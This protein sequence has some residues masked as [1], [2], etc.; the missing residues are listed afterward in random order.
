[1]THSTTIRRAVALTAAFLLATGSGAA[2]QEAD[3]SPFANF[4]LAG[5]GGT[6]YEAGL[7]SDFQNDFSASVSPV[8][9]YSM[10]EDLLFEAE[11][12]F[13]LSGELTTTTL[14]YA[15][16]D[17]LGFERVQVT[18]GKFLLPFGLFGERYHPTWVNELPSAP[19]LFGHAHGGVAEEALMPILSDAGAMVRYNHPLGGGASNLDLSL[20]VTQGPRLVTASDEEGG[21]GHA[22]DIVPGEAAGHPVQLSPAQSAQSPFEIPQVGFGVAFADNNQ[23]KMLGGRLGWVNGGSFEIHLS[24]FHAMYDPDDFLD[25]S[26]AALSFDTRRGAWE[27]RG[28]GVFLRQEFQT[29]GGTF[30]TLETPGYYVQL[31]R[32]AGAFE[33]VVR[34]SQLLDGEVD[35]VT[36]RPG[37]EEL[38]LGV[39]Y[40]LTPTVPLKVAYDVNPDGDDGMM[41]Q[42]AFGF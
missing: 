10:G 8:L 28:E 18:A 34:W 14:E 38:A 11:L 26:G 19:L 20:Y 21:D 12:E 23:N 22:H 30:E 36:A 41:V 39:N 4:V 37:I 13:G 33:P 42:W 9:L 17:Y 32:R 7:G 3:P 15:Q 31:S 25:Y 29:V 40:W 2:A 27:L 16:V 6:T 35:G 24:G 1:M 5:Y